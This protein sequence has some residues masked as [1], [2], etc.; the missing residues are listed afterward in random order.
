MAVGN[1]TRR[2]TVRA[3][4]G[5]RFGYCRVQPLVR[6]DL[7]DEADGQRL[8]R[9]DHLSGEHQPLR[10]ARPHAPRC[11]LRAAEPGIDADAGLREGQRRLRRGDDGVAGE[12]ELDAAAERE[13]VEARDDRLGARFD[14]RGGAPGRAW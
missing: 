1:A 13:A 11:P 4:R 9:A 10:Q 12:R 2:A 7:V 5:H 8:V 3:N 14:A 6:H